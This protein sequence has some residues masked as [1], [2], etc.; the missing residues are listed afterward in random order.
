MPF[1]L[2]LLSV[3]TLGAC[4]PT[5]TQRGNMVSDEQIQQIQPGASTRSDVLKI[6][7]SPTTVAP[8]HANI[9]YYIGQ[10]TE[11]RGILDPE[12]KEERVIVVTFYEDGTVEQ[13]G[14]L[15]VD[16]ID[17][18]YERTKT[19]THGNEITIMQQLLGNVGRFNP[20]TAQ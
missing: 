11:K 7:G 17:I 19:Q 10:E 4:T 9:W 16:R 13:A 6:M 8:F 2:A 3:L 1:I 12:V 20:N 18:P 5:V 14:E 15:D